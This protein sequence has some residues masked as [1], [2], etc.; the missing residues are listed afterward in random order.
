MISKCQSVVINRTKFS[1]FEDYDTSSQPTEGLKLVGYVETKDYCSGEIIKKNVAVDYSEI[2]HGGS[3]IT[4]ETIKGYFVDN[5][6][7]FS[8]LNNYIIPSSLVPGYERSFRITNTFRGELIQFNLKDGYN[9]NATTNV[10]SNKN[11]DKVLAFSFDRTIPVGKKIQILIKG[12]PVKTI[13]NKKF[14]INLIDFENMG[15][16]PSVREVIFESDERYEE[17]GALKNILITFVQTAEFNV[18]ADATNGA[19]SANRRMTVTNVE[20]IN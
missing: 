16:I 12:F 15:D 18:N 1:D 13:N 9:D 17:S 20:F 10:F 8:P 2:A 11:Q 5:F 19:A 7:S 3:T 14:I 4:E 6:Q